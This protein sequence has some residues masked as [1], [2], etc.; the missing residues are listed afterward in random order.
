MSVAKAAVLGV[1]IAGWAG[2]SAQADPLLF[3]GTFSNQ[4]SPGV[5][6]PSISAPEPAG[7]SASPNALPLGVSNATPALG[8]QAAQALVVAPA[9]ASSFDPPQPPVSPPPQAPPTALPPSG[10][11]D[12]F[13]NLGGGPYP[14]VGSLTTGN[15]SPWFTSGP[16]QALYGGTPTL[17]QQSDFDNAVIQRVGQTFRQSGINISLTGDPNAAAAHTISVV[18]NTANP[19]SSQAIGMTF[20]GGNGFHFI[21]QSAKYAQTIDQLEWVVAHNVAH[22]LMLAFGVPENHDTT[23]QF[24]D[25][26][27]A[28]LA[29][30]INPAAQFSSGATQDLLSRNFQSTNSSPVL[31]GAQFLEAPA[32]PEPSTVALWLLGGPAL[33]LGKQLRAADRRRLPS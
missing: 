23:G 33:W 5:F 25:A 12:A 20:V 3:L 1:L 15:A 19:S 8:V 32:V 14:N 11:Y 28:D 30:M 4:S 26:R 24:V 17:Q 21:D 9:A 13:I 7:S 22:E 29:M 10:V 18:A 2:P 16:V 31:M 27:N 6:S